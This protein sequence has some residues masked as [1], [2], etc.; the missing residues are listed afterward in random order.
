M[1]G[2]I[3]AGLRCEFKVQPHLMG[4]VV[5]IKGAR[6]RQTQQECRIDRVVVDRDQSVVRIV[7]ADPA[8]VR[9]AR[10]ML[11]LRQEVVSVPD[12][13]TRRVIIGK[14]GA[15]IKDVQRRSG[16]ISIDVD[17][18]RGEVKVLGTASAAAAAKVL[19]E[20]FVQ[21]ILDMVGVASHWSPYDR[22]RVVNADP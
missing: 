2:E 4:L 9:K 17:H 11:E 14:G 19:V 6:I 15:T 8:E 7:G 1:Q 18:E 5:G 22:V 21:N 16:A 3:D 20:S 13:K 10:G 12:D